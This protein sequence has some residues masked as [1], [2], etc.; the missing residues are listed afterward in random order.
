[1][2]LTR[3]QFNILASLATMKGDQIVSEELDLHS[4]TILLML[5]LVTIKID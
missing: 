5:I 1:M 3:E 4:D 2:N